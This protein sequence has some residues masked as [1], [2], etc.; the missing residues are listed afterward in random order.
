MGRWD[1]VLARAEEARRAEEL[2]SIEFASA[3]LIALTPLHIHQGDVVEAKRLLESLQWVGNSEEWQPP[4]VLLHDQRDAAP[5][6]GSSGGSSGG[7]RGGP[8][9]IRAKLGLGLASPFFKGALV[10]AVEAFFDLG[11]TSGAEALLATVR[12]A[13]PGQVTPW[14]RAQVARLTAL[15]SAAA[16]DHA[17]VDSGS[18]SAEAGFRAIQTPFDLAVTLTEHADWLDARGRADQAI[19]L[20]ANAREIFERLGARPWLERVGPLVE[21]G[22]R[23]GRPRQRAPLLPHCQRRTRA[24]QK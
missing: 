20:R 3:S 6:R 19:S 15:G 8:R 10:E 9:H 23:V 7:C 17:A 18:E 21:L 12:A 5:R 1:E 4:P 22:E 13:R 11:D 2:A 24:P 16:G 14:L